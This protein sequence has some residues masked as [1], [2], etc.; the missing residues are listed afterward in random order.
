MK[1]LT[2]IEVIFI[3][4]ILLLISFKNILS[5]EPDGALRCYQCESDFGDASNVCNLHN[6]KHANR[7]EKRDM[8]MQCPRRKSSFCHIVIMDNTNDVTTSRGCAGP[9]FRDGKVAHVGCMHMGEGRRLCLCETNLCN[10]AVNHGASLC[11][12]QLLF[13]FICFK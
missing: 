6:W 4:A 1:S 13:L 5:R 7:T 8:I 9:T 11:T 10:N 3:Q 2:T 12:F